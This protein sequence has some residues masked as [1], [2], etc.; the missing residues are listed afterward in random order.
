MA[1]ETLTVQTA[2]R[3]GAQMALQSI[4]TAGG[5]KFENN[6]KTMLYVE[7]NVG[8]LVLTFAIQPTLD[9]QAVAVKTVTVTASEKWV[10][11]PFPTRWY[12][13]ADDYIICTCDADLASGVG[14]V[15]VVG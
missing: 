13:D 5:F 9:G 12:N 2:D 1:L 3:T 7:N 8:D 10:V 15:S 11:G 6:G 14:L 4:T